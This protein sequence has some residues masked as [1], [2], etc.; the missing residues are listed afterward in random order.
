MQLTPSPSCIKV[1]INIGG[2]INGVEVPIS[3]HWN[4]QQPEVTTSD[5]GVH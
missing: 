3:S 1:D 4:E 2:K 5:E